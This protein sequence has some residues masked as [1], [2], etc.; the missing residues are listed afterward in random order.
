MQKYPNASTMS[1]DKIKRICAGR[2]KSEYFLTEKDL[3]LLPCWRV[4]NPHY[5]SAAPMRLYEESAVIAASIEK[6]EQLRYLAEHKEEIAKA[7]RL[8]AKARAHSAEQDAILQIAKFQHPKPVQ[9]GSTKLPVEIWNSIM[10]NFMKDLEI[11]GIRTIMVVARDICSAAR[12]CRDLWTAGQQTLEALA[13]PLQKF[14]PS[15]LKAAVQHPTSLKLPQ[16]KLVA[17]N[18]G[19]SMTGTKAV[20]IMRILEHCGLTSNSNIPPA[21]LLIAAMEKRSLATLCIPQHILAQAYNAGLYIDRAET[22]FNARKILADRFCTHRNLMM[23]QSKQESYSLTSTCA[24]GNIPSPLC[25]HCKRCCKGPCRRHG[26]I[27]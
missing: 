7:K 27:C 14:L 25:G 22:V 19:C 18:M 15:D 3:E 20:V 5:R 23:L 12:T 4:S 16:L 26:H 24:C 11:D 13:E 9:G 2:A 1:D 6:A 17:K 8:I 21:L 10:R